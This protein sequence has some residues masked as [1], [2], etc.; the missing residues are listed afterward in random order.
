MQIGTIRKKALYTIAVIF[1]LY[2]LGYYLLCVV[3]TR[4]TMVIFENVAESCVICGTFFAGSGILRNR[5]GQLI[6]ET[7]YGNVN[8][9][10]EIDIE[11]C[12]NKK[13]VF[14][15]ELSK[16]W[17][18]ENYDFVLDQVDLIN[19]VDEYERATEKCFFR[20]EA[21]GMR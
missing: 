3:S 6:I 5:N 13:V 12:Y 15:G 1:T 4:G 9:E 8:I 2:W 17:F 16:K 7:D 21:F 11:H 10:E 20:P 19:I 18:H 14:M